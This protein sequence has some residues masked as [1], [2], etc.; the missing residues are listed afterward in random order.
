MNAL[1]RAQLDDVSSLNLLIAESARHL[2][3]AFYQPEQIAALITHVFGVDTQLIR[4]ATYFVMERDAQVIACGGWSARRTLFGGDQTKHDADPLLSP[5]TDAARIRA[6][7]VH[8]SVARQGLGRHLLV[9]CE[10]AA[11]AAGF[12]RAEL[13]ATLPGEPLY[14]ALGYST[15][16]RVVHPLPNGVTVDLV[17][18]GR[19]LR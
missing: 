6:F 7:F 13:M 12:H 4:D 18:M 5:G 8:P 17:R 19:A 16:E 2:S 9:H 10:R 3:R 15:L 11:L 1:R 14:S